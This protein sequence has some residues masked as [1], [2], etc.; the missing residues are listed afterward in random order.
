MKSFDQTFSKVWPP[1]GPLKQSEKGVQKKYKENTIL[2]RFNK[3]NRQQI[4]NKRSN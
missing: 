1:A 4:C 3:R 2:V